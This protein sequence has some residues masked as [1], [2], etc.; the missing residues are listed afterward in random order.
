[1]KDVD[2]KVLA[3][4]VDVRSGKR[5]LKGDTFDPTPGL[6][7]AQRLVKAGCLPEGAIELAAKS[8]KKA[9]ADAADAKKRESSHAALTAANSELVDARASLTTAEGAVAAASTD[10][11]RVSSAKA[12]DEAKER[13]AEAEKTVKKLSS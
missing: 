2:L 6:E 5:F 4:C 9:D 3:E 12:L 1:M 7:Q 13:V 8:A 11:D 10:D